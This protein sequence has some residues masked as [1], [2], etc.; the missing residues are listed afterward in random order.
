MYF[1]IFLQWVILIRRKKENSE[2]Q[3][4][5]ELKRW[6]FVCPQKNGYSE[7]ILCVV[8]FPPALLATG[9]SN[10]EIILWNA[11]AG[12]I[13]CRFVGP[14][15]DKDQ[16]TE[17]DLK[18]LKISCISCISKIQLDRLRSKHWNWIHI[19][20][21]FH[22]R[23]GYKC[24]KHGFYQELKTAAAFAE[25][26]SLDTWSQRLALKAVKIIH[27]FILQPSTV[28]FITALFIHSVS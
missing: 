25:Y 21:R 5:L 24:S 22:N 12:S 10:G 6:D 8:Q 1:Q 27:N 16:N 20:F 19:S 17:G 26:C 28:Y 9:S 7:D 18:V 13:N 14:L 2:L 11:A 15:A 4:K 3:N 23:T